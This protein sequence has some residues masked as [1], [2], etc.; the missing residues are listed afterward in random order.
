MHTVQNPKTR[1][2]MTQIKVGK[3]KLNFNQLINSREI[4]NVSSIKC[5]VTI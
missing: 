4:F 1:L 5:Y 2:F 3:Q